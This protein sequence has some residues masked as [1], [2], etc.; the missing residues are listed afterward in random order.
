VLIYVP[1][2]HASDIIHYIGVFYCKKVSVSS[3]KD[4]IEVLLQNVALK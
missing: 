2:F 3:I 1:V 4:T